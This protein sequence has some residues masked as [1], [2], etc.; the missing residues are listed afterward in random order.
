[1]A[2]VEIGRE[3]RNKSRTTHEARGNRSGLKIESR[4]CPTDVASPFDTV[5]WETRSAAIKDESKGLRVSEV[6][7]FSVDEVLGDR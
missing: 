3:R 7:M 1:M 4:F 2:T 6:T 5:Q